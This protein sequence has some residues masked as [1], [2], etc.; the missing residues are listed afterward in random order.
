MQT[1]RMR[2]HDRWCLWFL[3]LSPLLPILCFLLLI[4]IIGGLASLGTFIGFSTCLI[5][6]MNRS[7]MP[8]HVGALREFLVTDR[9]SCRCSMLL[10]WRHSLCLLLD[11]GSIIIRLCRLPLRKLDLRHPPLFRM[12][13]ELGSV[14]SLSM[15]KCSKRSGQVVWVNV[16]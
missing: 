15:M 4:C 12:M 11:F 3:C 1:R 8:D 14:D 9:T 2:R 6:A 5:L 13:I 7:K 10:L 16:A